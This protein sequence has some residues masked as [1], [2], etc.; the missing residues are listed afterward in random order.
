MY[1]SWVIQHSPVDLADSLHIM[2]AEL[3]WP[4]WADSGSIVIQAELGWPAEPLKMLAEL[5][6]WCLTEL[7]CW[8]LTLWMNSVNSWRVLN[9]PSWIILPGSGRTK[10]G[11]PARWTHRVDFTMQT[12][13]AN[14]TWWIWLLRQILPLCTLQLVTK[15]A[16]RSTCRTCEYY[17]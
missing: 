5:N 6:C 11:Q 14:L 15:T 7:W 9:L 16:S 17:Y 1:K 10:P 3:T 8:L 13:E 4:S 2:N 12:Q